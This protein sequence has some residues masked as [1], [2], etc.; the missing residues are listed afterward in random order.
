[1]HFL[2]N[3]AMKRQHPVQKQRTVADVFTDERERL[4]PLPEA[5]TPT[6]LVTSAPA[7]KTAL[8]SFDTNR[9]SVPP[10]AANRILT[11]VASDVEVRLLDRDRVVAT[12]VRSWAK[13]TTVEDPAHRAAI[14]ATKPG[15]RDGKGRDRLRAEIPHAD[16]LMR[17]WLEDGR[18]VGSLVARTLKLLDL[19]GASIVA[20]AVDDLLAKGGHDLG[21]LAILVAS[22]SRTRISTARRGLP[23]DLN[24]SNRLVPTRMPGGVAGDG[25]LNAR[26]PHA[27]PSESARASLPPIRA[28]GTRFDPSECHVLSVGSLAV[29]AADRDENLGEVLED[30]LA[31]GEDI[32]ALEDTATQ[33]GDAPKVS[34]GEAIGELP[35]AAVEAHALAAAELALDLDELAPAGTQR[36]LGRIERRAAAHDVLEHLDVRAPVRAWLDLAEPDA[37]PHGQEHVDRPVAVHLGGD[38][39]AQRPDREQCAVVAARVF[40]GHDLREDQL[41]RTLGVLVRGEEIPGHRSVTGLE[42]VE[43]DLGAGQRD[44]AGHGKDWKRRARAHL[45]L[46]DAAMSS[47]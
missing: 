9:Y 36:H 41:P 26:R 7:D 2:E 28:R 16:E 21:A 10:E 22:L 12:H 20:S 1:M 30:E 32:V 44:E 14:L 33:P 40:A 23:R 46:L 8:V 6:E 13:N 11:L 17:R 47:R 35:H 19:Y 34:I 45:G 15:A 25:G 5:A 38:H 18:N 43:A 31:A 4:M 42:E 39:A 27:D 3:V 29:G 37:G 24:S